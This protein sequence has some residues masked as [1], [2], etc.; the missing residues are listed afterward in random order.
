M[1]DDGSMKKHTHSQVTCLDGHCQKQTVHAVH[2]SAADASLG[3]THL[4][5]ELGMMGWL[6]GLRGT[7]P[8]QHDHPVQRTSILIPAQQGSPEQT[9]ALVPLQRTARLRGYT[10]Q[11]APSLEGA[12]QQ[13]AA[14][15]PMFM[16]LAAAVFAAALILVCVVSALFK[17]LSHRSEA[18]AVSVRSTLAEPLAPASQDV[19]ALAVGTNKPGKSEESGVAVAVAQSV[20]KSYLS[21]LYAE[22]TMPTKAYLLRVYTKALA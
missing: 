8:A 11:H 16:H 9:P 13:G 12:V 3:S 21:L 17:C 22:V 14:A 18:R 1:Y 2:P 10:M 7:L 6:L 15:T 4:H 5:Q 20:A 19:P